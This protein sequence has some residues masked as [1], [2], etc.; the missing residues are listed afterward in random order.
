MD[1]VAYNVYAQQLFPKG[2]GYP[3]WHPEHT[4]HG[5]IQLGDVGYYREGAF[6]R[7]FN[8]LTPKDDPSQ[9]TFGVPEGFEPFH[10]HPYLLNDTQDVIKAH[11]HSTSVTSLDF[12]G[13]AGTQLEALGAGIKY[14]C[15]REHG[16]FVF[17][18]PSADRAQMHP[19]RSFV[20][21]MRTTHESWYRFA[22]DNLDLDIQREELL[23]VAGVV[24][25]DD[26][27]LGAFLRHGSGGEVAFQT[28]LGPFA[29]GSFSFSRQ[30]ASTGLVDWRTKPASASLS[31]T[32][33]MVSP[34]VSTSEDTASVASSSAVSHRS[35]ITL[36][37]TRS[38]PRKD[39]SLFLNYYKMKRRLWRNRVIKA[40]ARSD[41]RDHSPG[42]DGEGDVSMGSDFEG[43]FEVPGTPNAYDPVD[44]VLD[45]ILDCVL[46]DGSSAETA[47]AGSEHLYQLFG[48]DFPEDI[49]TALQKLRPQILFV[50][51]GVAA[52]ACAEWGEEYDDVVGAEE[53]RAAQKH[54]K[55][56]KEKE[57]EF[58]PGPSRQ[59]DPHDT[60]NDAAPVD[61]SEEYIRKERRQRQN[62]ANPASVV[63]HDHTGGVTCAVWSPD[64][65][66]IASGSEDTTV[67][68][69]DGSGE[70]IHKFVDHS[71]AVWTLAFSRD[72]KY[73]ASG[74]S[75]GLG[76]IWDVETRAVAA[77][78][79]GDNIAIQ[80]LHY[81]PDSTKL[82]TSSVDFSV[83]VWDASSGTLLHTMTEHTAVV[84]STAFSPNGRWLASCSADYTAKIWDVQTGA[85]HTTLE[86]HEGIVWSVA[87]DPESRRVVTGSDDATS[88]VWSAE[89]GDALVILHEHPAA[90][91]AV[92]FSP[93]GQQVLSASNDMTIKLCNSFTGVLEHTFDRHDALVNAAVFSPDGEYVASSGG[94]NEVLVWNAKTGDT[95]PAMEGH[96]DKVTA[97]QFS[98][99]GDRLMSAS[100]DGTV[101]IWTLPEP[102]PEDQ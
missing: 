29:Q 15:Q 11:V 86:G 38:G 19:A 35:S 65:R 100:D 74:A 39:Q 22:V 90:V 59:V 55:K 25:T 102:E 32:L 72:S 53:T 89:T 44:Y 34:S 23:F 52:L 87:F 76:L 78:L 51:D 73:L 80:T 17:V 101:R 81:S 24:K 30:S 70:F 16:A 63:L 36:K 31:P 12:S 88:R 5:E 42:S 92:A 83:R 33:S 20:Q 69:R 82:A 7:L 71:D 98:A 6:F 8:A 48:E 2:F 68:L 18:Q 93:D 13:N 14:T 91:W 37:R 45:Y 85:L 26:W 99:E 94:D 46:E 28:N 27:G 62:P 97:L 21:Y 1:P 54:K 66:Y 58:E 40:A 10:V 9:K 75:N 60:A 49:P 50:D 3:L 56:Q 79:E 84:L 41:E 95:L 47:I 57:M 61:D 67:I 4:K 43:P 64:G 96:I 77:V